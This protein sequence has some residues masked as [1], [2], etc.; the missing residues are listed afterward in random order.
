MAD[1]LLI[2][3]SSSCHT[4]QRNAR[5]DQI[6]CL[7]V[8]K[9]HSPSQCELIIY[10]TVKRRFMCTKVVRKAARVCMCLR[11]V[12]CV[13]MQMRVFTCA[14]TGAFHL[15]NL[16]IKLNIYLNTLLHFPNDLK[17]TLLS[18]FLSPPSEV[19]SYVYVQLH[20]FPHL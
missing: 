3:S 20:S 15:M 10:H 11:E 6:V 7:K 1:R 18:R 12:A 2:T 5:N 14:F 17:L 19:L 4:S 8:I 9:N 16:P 13:Y